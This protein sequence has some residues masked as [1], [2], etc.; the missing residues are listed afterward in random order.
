MKVLITGGT[1]FI[2]CYFVRELLDQGHQVS[3]L[4]IYPFEPGVDGIDPTQVDL[5]IG[6]IRDPQALDQSMQGCDAV[7]HLAAAHHDFGISE[8]TFDSVN[9]QGARAICEAMDRHGISNAC[10][11]SSV[12]VYGDASPPVDEDSPH[13]AV[14]P[15]GKTKSGAEKVFREWVGAGPGRRCLVIRPTVTFG[16]GNFANM[17]TLI[18]Q[19]DKGLFM[20]VGDGKNIK[21]LSYIENIVD[22]TMNQWLQPGPEQPAF[23]TYNYVCKPDLTSGE[24]ADIVYRALGKKPP[25]FRVPYGLARILALP[26]DV[27]IALT[28]KNLPVSGARIWKLAK[29]QTRYE[30]SKIRDAGYQQKVPLQE[31]IEKMV[32]WYV[33]SGKQEA[34]QGVKRRLPPDEPQPMRSR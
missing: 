21:S 25:G 24:I 20:P 8:A 5:V 28:G 2:G 30:S 9:V 12:A 22:A 32:R 16:A 13:E 33:A 26:L 6:D 4:D 7:L 11:Y 17:F 34:E 10:F 29:A 23:V 18:K 15:Y 19:I 1:G 14:S 3:I 27:V 31:G